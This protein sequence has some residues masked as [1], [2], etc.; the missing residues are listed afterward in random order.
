MIETTCRRCGESA[1]A[2]SGAIRT[3]ECAGER[4]ALCERCYD[5]L[6]AWFGDAVGTTAGAGAAA[7]GASGGHQPSPPLVASARNRV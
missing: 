1:L 4:H 3:I 6:R 7:G 5:E 2:P